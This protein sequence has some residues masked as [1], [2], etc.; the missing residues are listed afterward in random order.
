MGNQP[1][2]AKMSVTRQD[3]KVQ[4]TSYFNT[5]NI[6]TQNPAAFDYPCEDL[7]EEMNDDYQTSTANSTALNKTSYSPSNELC[8]SFPKFTSN[9]DPFLSSPNKTVDGILMQNKTFIR[10]IPVVFKYSSKNVRFDVQLVGSFTNWKNKIQMIKSDGDYVAIVD[11]PEGEHQYKFVVD[12][13]WEYDPTQPGIDDTFNGKNNLVVV[14]KSDFEVMEALAFDS[15]SQQQSSKS[16]NNDNLS[17]SPSGDYTDEIP[18]RN[19]SSS[20]TDKPP[21]LPPQLLNIVLNKD[22]P[23]SCEPALLPEPHHVMLKHLYALSIRDGVMVLSS[24][25]RHKQKFITTCFYKPI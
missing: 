17:K 6:Y 13:K 21:Y 22:T 8:P 9:K 16:N 11:L 15:I 5:G 3:P 14:K 25:F 20:Y 7:N 23:A 4:P 24:T 10:K 1:S 12:G 18:S 2:N 19:I